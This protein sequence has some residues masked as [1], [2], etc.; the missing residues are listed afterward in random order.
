MFFNNSTRWEEVEE[1]PIEVANMLGGF[2]NIASDSVPNG[3]PPM[4]KISHQMDL[5]QGA[6]SPNKAAHIRH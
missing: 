5:I 2:S 4:R 6:S 3:L 1:V